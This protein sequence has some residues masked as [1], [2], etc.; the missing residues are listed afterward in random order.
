M[1]IISIP[2]TQCT[3]DL[4]IIPDQS[5][6]HVDFY[7]WRELNPCYSQLG[8]ARNRTWATCL[9]VL[10]AK[11][12]ATG[13]HTNAIWNM[14]Y[15]TLI[16]MVQVDIFQRKGNWILSHPTWNDQELNP[17]HLHGSPTA[18]N[19]TTVTDTNAMWN[20]LYFTFISMVQLYIFQRK[21]NWSLATPTWNGQELNTGHLLGSLT[22]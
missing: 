17:G 1:G 16:C 20:M 14:F 10:P 9:G 13:I 3:H 4:T 12:Y 2:C 18:N 5:S 15:L 7:M 21:G 19:Y 22:C 11:H 8:M 6:T